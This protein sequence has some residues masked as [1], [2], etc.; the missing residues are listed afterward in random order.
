VP[1]G[2][3]YKR[4]G[5]VMADDVSEVDEGRPRT[6]DDFHAPWEEFTAKIEEAVEHSAPPGKHAARSAIRHMGLAFTHTSSPETAALHAITA[7]EEA[8]TAIFRALQRRKYRGADRLNRHS[9]YHKA[10]VVPFFHAVAAFI[11]ETL[12]A[13]NI[14][15]F[16]AFPTKGEDRRL[17]IGV[18][19]RFLEG[20][21]FPIPPLHG[22]FSLNDQL[23][24]FAAE[25]QAWAA[26]AGAKSISDAV[27][28][29][30]ER[31]VRIWYA[32]EQGIPSL[33]LGDKFL[34]KTRDTMYGQLAVFLLIDQ[35]SE[36]Q[37][38]VQQALDAF[39][40]MLPRGRGR[41]GA[42]DAPGGAA[43]T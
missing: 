13:N 4:L 38:F 23:Y 41:A 11:G 10:A 29:R 14:K 37:L 20:A 7:E 43:P 5:A 18:W 9:H 42:A 31:R 3:R 1:V 17:Q 35:H 21:F 40:R 27:N 19:L 12:E 26:K 2:L 25:L 28:A 22:S 6:W 39:L 24:D 30:A 32:A 34:T 8:S 15:V 33:K 16:P 36:Q